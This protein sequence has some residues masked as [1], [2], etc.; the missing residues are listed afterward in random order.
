MST[1]LGAPLT[2]E[3]IHEMDEIG[4]DKRGAEDALKVALNYHANRISTISK[5]E[6]AWWNRVLGAR[7]L[8]RHTC[9][10]KLKRENSFSGI[11][12]DED[13]Q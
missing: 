3:E 6:V 11:V 8:D 2:A 10:Y 1:F 13:S 5:L 4:S 9:A 7:G 12:K